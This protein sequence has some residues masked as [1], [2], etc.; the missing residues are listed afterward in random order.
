MPVVLPEE[1]LDRFR[2]SSRDRLSRVEAA[3][4]SLCEGVAPAGTATEMHRNVHTLKG[5]ARMVQFDDIN[6]VCQKLEDL[7][8]VADAKK[9]QVDSDFDLVVTMALDFV[10]LMLK[11]RTDQVVSGIDLRGFATQVKQ[12]LRNVPDPTINTQNASESGEASHRQIPEHLSKA[13]RMRLAMAA[14]RAFLEYACASGSSRIRLR[15]VWTS[16]QHEIERLGSI[17]LSPLVNRHACSTTELAESLGANV[18]VNLDEHGELR[19]SD[20]A[21]KALDTALMH[22]LGNAVSHGV[23]SKGARS[24]AGKDLRSCITIVTSADGSYAQVAVRDDGPGIDLEQVRRRALALGLMH[25]D[26][27]GGA[28]TSDLHEVLFHSKFTTRDVADDVAGRGVGLNAARD[29]LLQVGGKIKVA[30]SVG[31]GTTLSMLVPLR[32]RRIDVN[33]FDSYG[34]RVVFAVPTHWEITPIELNASKDPIDP[35]SSLQ[36]SRAED[37]TGLVQSGQ[38]KVLRLE[39]QAT[40]VELVI[41]G[42]VRQVVADR[43]C[44][45]PST[46][47]VEVIA[48]DGVEV[49]LL[50][51]DRLPEPPLP[52]RSK[53][54]RW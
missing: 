28:S 23:E 54:G 36:I 24:A 48:V 44:P 20:A 32:S 38:P 46:Y 53:K 17:S 34:G 10:G 30:S 6:L 39:T 50:R 4:T 51:P 37:D 47:P 45:T 15:S 18:S 8:A 52:A 25:P 16:L 29:A 13:S 2:A 1:I 42:S 14:T 9:Y 41:S 22:V 26:V 27:A 12:V 31:S 33:I 19:I 21:S 5:D 3:W 35:L 49:L 40:T 7:L 11:R 43:I